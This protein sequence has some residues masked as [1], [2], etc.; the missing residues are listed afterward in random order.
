MKTLLCAALLAIFLGATPAMAQATTWQGV[1]IIVYESNPAIC[2]APSS[3]SIT[4]RPDPAHKSEG[5][6][7][8]IRSDLDFLMTAPHFA[9][10]GAYAGT[11]LTGNATLR[12]LAGKF[13]LAVLPLAPIIYINGDIYGFAGLA[14]CNLGILSTLIVDAPSQ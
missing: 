1:G 12:V 10:V 8:R 3:F 11:T 5:L 7:I 9:G 14:G 4:Y 13:S 2:P 6:Q